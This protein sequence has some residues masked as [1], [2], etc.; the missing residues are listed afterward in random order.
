MFG[1]RKAQQQRRSIGQPGAIL[2]CG[3]GQIQRHLGPPVIEGIKKDGRGDEARQRKSQLEID[4]VPNVLLQLAQTDEIGR[5]AAGLIP[6]VLRQEPVVGRIERAD[7][8]LG[9]EQQLDVV[10]VPILLQAALKVV[11]LFIAR[12]ENDPVHIAGLHGCDE[13]V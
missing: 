7:V 6:R 5:G 9:I 8:E 11:R 10:L 12:C 4:D 2:E 1:E 3:V 13:L